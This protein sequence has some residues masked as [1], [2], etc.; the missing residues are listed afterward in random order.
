M[1]S[2]RRR[3]LQCVAILLVATLGTTSVDA[4]TIT[5]AGE[6]AQLD[7]RAA[8]ERSIRITLKPVSFKEEFPV[9][10]AVVARSYASPA[11]SLRAVTRPVRKT[12]G[13][14]SVEVR[15]NPLTAAH[16]EPAP[17]PWSRRSSSRTTAR[18]RSGSTSTPCSAWA[19]AVRCRS[20]DR[21]WREQP[22][23]FDR[24]GRL[25][26]MQPRWQA[27]MYGSRNPVAMLLGTGGWGLFV[28][29]PWGQVDL[30][31]ADRGVFIPWKP[32]DAERVPQNERNQQQALAKGLPPPDAVVPGLFDVFVFDAADP[33]Q[34]LKDFSVDHRT[35]G[36]AAAVGARATCSRTGR[37]RTTRRCSASP[38]RS[39]ASRFRSMR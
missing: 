4:Q 20:K 11:L 33:A 5:A 24:R 3:A 18:S 2:S 13:A 17:A 31:K 28:A 35:R 14:L 16:H 10:P 23:Q 7:V 30:R 26:T 36:D 19:K 12:V 38:R 9:N 15:P 27:D 25:D 1:Q 29:A 21:P 34:A 32:S 6:P 22:V 37:S 39:V 8:G